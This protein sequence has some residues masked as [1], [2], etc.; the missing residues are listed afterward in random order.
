[1]G[2]DLVGGDFVVAAGQTVV[3]DFPTNFSYNNFTMGDNSTL[4]LKRNL[5]LRAFSS[6]FGNN[7][8]IEG[9]GA[10][11]A[12]NGADQTHVPAQAGQL[13]AGYNGWD[14]GN[15]QT[16]QAGFNVDFHLGIHSIGSLLIRSN[17]GHGGNGGRGG[18][19]GQGGGATCL[20]GPGGSGGHGGK[21]GRAGWGGPSGQI[22]FQWSPIGPAWTKNFATLMR[23]LEAAKAHGFVSL[24]SGQKLF[25]ASPP[26]LTVEATGGLAG[27][28]GWAGFGGRGGDGVSCIGYGQPGGHVGDNGQLGE[29]GLPGRTYPPIVVL[30]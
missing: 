16:G 7:C 30:A 25:Y 8:L 9:S 17:G 29:G 2:E 5:I 27:A 14:G 12:A 15:G 6:L 24:P 28:A 1:M 18:I 13:D 19:G 3:L 4:I 26:G 11:Q 10:A 20:G 23:E 21:G 22:K